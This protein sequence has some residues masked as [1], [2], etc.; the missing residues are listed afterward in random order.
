MQFV[1]TDS[2][3]MAGVEHVLWPDKGQELSIVGATERLEFPGPGISGYK[4]CVHEGLLM[5]VFYSMY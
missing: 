3:G 1:Q 5:R 2:K 4:H